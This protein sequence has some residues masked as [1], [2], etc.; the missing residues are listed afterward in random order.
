MI[1]LITCTGSR[2]EAFALSEKMIQR[3]T[4]KGALQWIVIDDSNPPT[5][6]TLKQEYYRGPKLWE[7]HYNTHRP[8]MEFAL[9][10]VKGE[11]VYIIEDDDWYAPNYLESYLQILKQVHIAGEAYARY[12]HVKVP[13][14]RQL[15]NHTHSALSQTAFRT[16]SILPF[17]VKAVNSGELYFDT[18]LWANIRAHGVSKALLSDSGLSVGMKGLP[19]RSGLTPSHREMRDYMYDVAHARLISWIGDDVQNYTHFSKKVTPPLSIANPQ[20]M[21]K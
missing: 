17:M 15:V 14:H 12:Y 4:Y 1:T 7:P 11:Y 16:K 13:G 2:P 19:G 10:K 8:N 3:Q 9:T 6:C 21:T 5:R 20:P 18:H